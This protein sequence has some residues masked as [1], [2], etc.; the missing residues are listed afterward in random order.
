MVFSK[1]C[2]I[3][4][5]ASSDCIST[6]YMKVQKYSKGSVH[7]GTSFPKPLDDIV[8][9]EVADIGGKFRTLLIWRKI[10]LLGGMNESCLARGYGCPFFTILKPMLLLF[11]VQKIQG[12]KRSL[13]QVKRKLDSI[14]N[15]EE[16]LVR[17]EGML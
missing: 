4:K 15:Q 5:D 12:N 17:R 3:G 2:S 10:N 7:A 8:V 13:I 9:K 11:K 16:G 14:I 6:A 1:T